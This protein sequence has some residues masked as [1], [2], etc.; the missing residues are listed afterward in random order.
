MITHLPP[1]SFLNLSSLSRFLSASPP[2]LLHLTLP[3]PSTRFTNVLMR[4]SSVLAPVGRDVGA[5]VLLPCRRR[6]HGRQ[7]LGRAA[8]QVQ[9]ALVQRVR[10]EGQ[11]AQ[12]TPAQALARRRSR[13]QH[14]AQHLRRAR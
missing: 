6:A 5:V 12:R 11:L 8:G 7:V 1:T 13:Q 2:A 3:I 9:R 14:R 4:C 10:E